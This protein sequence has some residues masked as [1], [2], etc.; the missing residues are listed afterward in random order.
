MFL[1]VR[2][3]CS[4]HFENFLM[5][6]GF[7]ISPMAEINVSSSRST[8]S[9]LSFSTGHTTPISAKKA[10]IYSFRVFCSGLQWIVKCISFS[11]APQSHTQQT[12]F[13]SANPLYLP[14]SSLN[15]KT[16]ALYLVTRLHLLIQISLCEDFCG[17]IVMD[18]D[19]CLQLNFGVTFYVPG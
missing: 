13:S 3:I 4:S 11:I 5:C 10:V 8:S 17:T 16:P 18:L 14:V 6:S 19:E 9:P 15:G 7:I 1:C 12:C 2:Y